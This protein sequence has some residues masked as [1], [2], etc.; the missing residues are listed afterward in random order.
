MFRD[1]AIV[2]Y[3]NLLTIARV[4]TLLVTATIQPLMFVFLFAYIFGASMGGGQYRE[5][6]LAGIFTQ[7]VAF[8]AAFTTVGLANDL[9]QGIID[10]MRTLPMSRLAVLMGRTLSDLVV[11]I[12]SL[13]VM[14]GCGYLVGWRINGGIASAA[15]AF[16]V[17]LLFA[18]AM[19][20]VGALTGLMSPS[21]EVAQSAGLIWLFPV[22]FVSSAFIS[23]ET[24]PGPL[25]TV[26]EWN[27]ITA[28]S[29]AGR[30]LFD[31][32]APPSFVPPRGWAADHCVEYAIGCSL[33]ILVVAVPLALLQ[34]RK[35]A[36]H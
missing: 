17:I 30:K 14:V 29:A 25:R 36:S 19:S 8:N 13:A 4:P 33:A 11:N 34:Y 22:T 35:V 28:V 2:A 5:F 23:A 12:A 15:L 9:Q 1:S 21:V 10:R 27:P 32:G 7:T 31:N 20:W 6:L 3:R 18:F 26:A 24:L 16:G